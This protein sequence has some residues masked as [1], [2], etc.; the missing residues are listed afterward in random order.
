MPEFQVTWIDVAIVVAY[1]VI[2]I[3]IGVWFARGKNDTESYFLGGR[4]FLWPLVGLSLFATNQSGSS[5]I[6]LSSSGYANGIAVFNYEWT[7]AVILVFFVVFFLPFYLRSRVYTMPEFL[8]RRFDNRSRYAHSA[9]T[10]LAETFIGLSVS[11]YAGGLALNLLFPSIPLWVTIA[12]LGVIAGGY[13][14]AG[15]LSAVVITDSIQAVF[16][17]I[18]S[19]V[20]TV[21]VFREIGSLSEVREAAPAGDPF[22]LIQPASS[23]SAV[24][25]PGLLT[26]ILII[27]I[28]FFCMNQIQVQR[29]LGARSLDDGRLGALLGG[30]LKLTLL[31]IIILPATMATA[32]YPNLENPDRIWPTLAFDLL[33]IGL[34][35]LVLAALVAALMSSID[36]TLNAL[37][38]VIT[39]D[40]VSTFR[41]DTSQQSLVLIGRISTALLLIVA[42]TWAPQITNFQTLWGYL[43]AAVSYLTP[44]IVAV[45]IL[46]IF[47]RRTTSLSSVVTIVVGISVGVV[48]F[49]MNE[50]IGVFQIHFLY[51][52][53][54]L[55]A[56]SCLLM[57]VIS[58]LTSPEPEEENEDLIWTLSLWHEETREL[59]EKP[60]YWN[61][62]YWSVALLAVTAVI[63]IIFW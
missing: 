7:G 31:F 53:A 9:Y 19:I 48:G 34:R 15:G 49:I 8:G 40:F 33:P 11:L 45:F 24:P 5:F 52:A 32:L 63:V 10:V 26:G 38:T 17:I 16:I 44:S 23:S 55:F 51:A 25:W 30:V 57:V 47:W 60:W 54:I 61:Y 41:P 6:G 50:V 29:V 13:T 36:S 1:I 62:R 4:N 3:G 22:S 27:G 28:Y 58:L 21:L 37:S 12:A 35:G 39:M 14:V 42:I 59:A 56:F 2:T 18:G 43:Q 46:G 20:I